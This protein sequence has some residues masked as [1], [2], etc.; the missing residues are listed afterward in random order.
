MGAWSLG[1]AAMWHLGDP[2]PLSKG[3]APLP[4]TSSRMACKRYF[5]W[6][7]D[8][9]R[10]CNKVGTTLCVSHI[11]FCA[12]RLWKLPP[13][14][15]KVM[16]KPPTFEAEMSSTL[17]FSGKRSPANSNTP[18]ASIVLPGLAFKCAELDAGC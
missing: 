14:L 3:V 4:F 6:P 12:F 9:S 10:A 8:P 18:L 13:F 7:F 5:S 1:E 16:E 2:G 11:P 17:T 15:G